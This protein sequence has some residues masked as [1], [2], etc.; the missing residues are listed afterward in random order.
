M[1]AQTIAHFVEY[2]I[3][4]A[5]DYRNAELALS[6]AIESNN[7]DQIEGAKNSV[8]RQAAN[9]SVAID[10]LTDRAALELALSK[11]QIRAALP[12]LCTYLDG[13]MRQGAFER[14][15]G[16]A[17]A[18]KHAML[19]DPRHPITSMADVITV[20]LGYGL[21]GYGVGKMGG[22]EVIVTQTN[23]TRFKFLGD[24]PAVLRGWAAYIIAQGGILPA[25]LAF[26]SIEI[27]GP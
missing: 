25:G 16:V 17:N 15:G 3:P 20:A 13:G 21:D 9:V 14:V 10:G 4:A 2:V 24:V 22:M 12:P 18:Y 23:G 27:T 8:L 26:G 1:L 19:T 5:T 7:Q 11:T 6:A